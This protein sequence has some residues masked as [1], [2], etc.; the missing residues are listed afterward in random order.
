MAKSKSELINEAIRVLTSGGKLTAEQRKLLG[1]SS[2][3][4]S[5]NAFSNLKTAESIFNKTTKTTPGGIFDTSNTALS[6]LK[7]AEGKLALVQAKIAAG[8]LLTDEDLKVLGEGE[9]KT[10]TSTSTSTTT[11]VPTMTAWIVNLLKNVPE[12]NNIYNSVKNEDGSFNRTVDVIIDMITSSKWY[13]DNGP[14]VAANIASRYKFGEK[15]YQEKVNQYKITISGLATAIGLDV[16]DPTVAEYLESLAET[17]FLSGWDEDYIE[18]KIISDDKV[19]GKINGGAYATAVDDLAEYGQLMGF[20]LSDTT[21]KDYQRRLIGEVT[22]GGLRSRTTSDQIKREIRDKQALL[23][24]MF[25]DDFAVGRTLWDVTASQRKIWA[26][27][28]EKSEDDL[29]W[30]DPLWKNGQIFTMTDE[31]TGKIVARPA[32]DAEKL[33]KQDERW[34]YTEN[35]NRLYEGYGTRILNK[36]GLAAI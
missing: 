12:L 13:L 7:E 1:Y 6:N 25:A 18:N 34:Q 15:F 35:A 19:I 10:S 23:Y 11:T 31:K 3:S 2:P 9:S 16:N 32:W 4:S 30:D 29:D 36:F 8:I 33:V 26:N 22:E 28:L 5:K 27:L 17:S 21:R 14:T 20:T 24:P